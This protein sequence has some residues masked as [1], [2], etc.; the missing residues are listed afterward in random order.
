MKQLLTIIVISLT[1][2]IFAQTKTDLK[3]YIGTYPKQT[4]FF[5]NQII[6]QE[7]K[8][9]LD[10]DFLK[11]QEH[12]SFSGS[13]EIKYKHGLIYG[14]VSQQHVGGYT[15]I[16]FVD[17]T[18]EKMHLFWLKQSVKD[19]DYYIYGDKPVPIDVMNLI[20]EKMNI[21]WGHV[22]SFNIVRDSIEIEIK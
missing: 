18:S 19:K 7:L 14:D 1:T 4:D 5:Q 11:Y 12:I 21:K 15:S 22:A 13:G 16:F 3:E 8:R 6:I 17:P 9:I 2:G 20:I 10:E